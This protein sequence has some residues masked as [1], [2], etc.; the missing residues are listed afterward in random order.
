MAAITQTFP[1]MWGI[2][3]VGVFYIV[4]VVVTGR[5][6]NPLELARGADENYSA[7]L[8]QF[9]IFTYL[10]V[11][12]YVAV[13]A[14]RLVSGLTTLPE[15]P[16]N[17][18]V[19]MGLSV[20]S[21]TASKGITI[22]YQE[23]GQQSGAGVFKDETGNVALIKVQMLIWTFIAAAIYFIT[24]VNFIN[25]KGYTQS[26]L[27]DVDGALLVLMGAAQGGY[28][29]GKLVSRSTGIPIIER[30][31]PSPISLNADTKITLLGGLFGDS[32]DSSTVVYQNKATGVQR[33]VPAA[34]VKQWA[35]SK[36]EFDIPNE[37]KTVGIYTMWVIV[38]GQKSAGTD[39]EVKV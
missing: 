34:S 25:T 20:I 38:K 30:I 36:I 2:I 39:I 16:L 35:D 18:L 32:Q 17:L 24:V 19:L 37:M 4:G 33:E 15:I 10:T 7:S 22:S 8:L 9:L 14:A 12:T 1:Y 27:P 5:R 21:A 13:Y 3:A 6:F 23:Q 26:A 11:F 28:I 31:V 29:G